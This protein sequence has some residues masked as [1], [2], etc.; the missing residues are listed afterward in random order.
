MSSTKSP[1]RENEIFIEL[2]Q[3][4]YGAQ[5]SLNLFDDG[6]TKTTITTATRIRVDRTRDSGNYCADGQQTLGGV[7][8]L[9]S[10]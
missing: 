10:L 8:M 9:I 6:T 2:D 3:I 7:L 5:Y 1:A 4:K